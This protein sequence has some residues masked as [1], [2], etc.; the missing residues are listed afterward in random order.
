MNEAIFKKLFPDEYIE[1]HLAEGAR[2]DSRP[3][4]AHRKITIQ[5]R[6]TEI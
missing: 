2:V 6:R 3:L 5:K 4:L 1:R